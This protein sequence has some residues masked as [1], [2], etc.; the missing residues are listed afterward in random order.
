MSRYNIHYIKREIVHY[1][2]LKDPLILYYVHVHVNTLGYVYYDLSLYSELLAMFVLYS[3]LLVT[4]QCV[5][6]ARSSWLCLPITADVPV[7]PKG[8]L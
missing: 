4:I 1:I 2:H 6:V 3:T 8:L 5:A 7:V